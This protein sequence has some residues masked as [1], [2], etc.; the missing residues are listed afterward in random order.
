VMLSTLAEA[1][2]ETPEAFRGRFEPALNGFE[3]RA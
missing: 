1:A 3:P 2:G